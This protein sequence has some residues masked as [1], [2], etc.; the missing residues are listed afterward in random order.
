MTEGEPMTE[1]RFEEWISHPRGRVF[2][3]IDDHQR[4]AGQQGWWATGWRGT[5]TE[6]ATRK[7][8]YAHMPLPAAELE[9]EP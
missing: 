4:Q 2:V 9:S 6:V 1:K 5:A 8:F 7:A 3:S